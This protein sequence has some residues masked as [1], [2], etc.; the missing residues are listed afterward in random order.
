MVASTGLGD[1]YGIEGAGADDVS[2][3]RG[4]HDGERD[5]FPS[6]LWI[7]LFWWVRSVSLPTSR[8]LQL[9]F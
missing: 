9:L 3:R 2:R 7:V 5:I 6:I 4:H 1:A 8:D